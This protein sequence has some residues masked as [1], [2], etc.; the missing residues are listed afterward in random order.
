MKK[1]KIFAKWFLKV[2][3]STLLIIFLITAPL[4]LFP[5]LQSLQ[6]NVNKSATFEYEGILE[7]WHIETF[8]GGS[9]SRANFL[10]KQAI[11]FEK[12]HKGSYIVIESMSL[13]QF[14]LNLANGKKPDILSFGI[15]IGD[16]ITD[17]L[18]D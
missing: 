6:A 15:G 1:L 17:S 13:E 4:T 11:A 18:I 10:E 5:N 12:K 8:E 2:G 16:G 3:I 7:L 14:K 9:V